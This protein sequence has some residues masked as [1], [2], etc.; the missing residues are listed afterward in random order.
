MEAEHDKQ[1][2]SATLHDTYEIG[3]PS[4]IIHPKHQSDSGGQV[5]AKGKEKGKSE[6]NQD[7][8]QRFGNAQRYIEQDIAD[9]EFED[10]CATL[11]RYLDNPK[12]G[13]T[14][15]AFSGHLWD[16][17]RTRIRLLVNV[18]EKIHKTKDLTEGIPG[19]MI[20][21]GLEK[22]KGASESKELY[23]D[24]CEAAIAT[25]VGAIDRK[26]ARA[27]NQ[28]T[29]N[30]M[31]FPGG[32]AWSISSGFQA[33]WVG[34]DLSTPF[35]HPR[36]C[37]MVALGMAGDIKDVLYNEIGHKPS[38][39]KQGNEIGHIV[40]LVLQE[41]DSS[42]KDQET[43][44]QMYI[45]DSAPGWFKD[46]EK[47]SKQAHNHIRDHF[48]LAAKTIGWT[49]DRNG[50][51]GKSLRV[52]PVA[53]QLEGW[54]CGYH[55]IYNAWI[56]ALGLTPSRKVSKE[57]LKRTC[58]FLPYLIYLGYKGALDWKTLA[59]FL[60]CSGLVTETD[61]HAVP[62]DRRFEKSLVQT[63]SERGDEIKEIQNA[64]D[65]LFDTEYDRSN[66]VDF[67][68]MGW[69][70]ADSSSE[71]ESSADRSSGEEPSEEENLQRGYDE[72]IYSP[73]DAYEYPDD[74][75]FLSDY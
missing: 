5:K 42:S 29:G 64:D 24:L 30:D 51:F 72:N 73:Y 12:N 35:A 45:L 3:M 26:K 17:C 61:L 14:L 75:D 46:I 36:R 52:V 13:L 27:W 44:Y 1:W 11:R 7:M 18:H 41:E 69:E 10:V 50:Q 53:E 21:P 23:D 22:K 31:G 40:L 34:M 32:F 8:K 62:D 19:N 33:A 39:T 63:R 37:W 48:E 70:G 65:I 47:K 16:Y 59:A 58:G 38:K 49:G 68:R 28:Q 57:N 43:E 66:N 20:L 2:Q 56:L 15:E 55:T 60:I 74:L 6:P 4:R 71:E 54:E 25:V 9:E 67:S